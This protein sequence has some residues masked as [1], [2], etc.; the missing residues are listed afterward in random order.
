MAAVKTLT[1]V[2]R[3]GVHNFGTASWFELIGV[4]S[5][6]HVRC[7]TESDGFHQHQILFGD[8]AMCRIRVTEHLHTWVEG[9]VPVDVERGS[10]DLSHAADLATAWQEITDDERIHPRDFGDLPDVPCHLTTT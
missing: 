3:C 4:C 7:W 2:S 10:K 1:R 6:V 8:D 5:C 9:P